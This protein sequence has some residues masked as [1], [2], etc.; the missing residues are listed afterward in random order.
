MGREVTHVDRQHPARM[1]RAVGGL[2]RTQAIGV[3][4]Q[5][6]DHLIDLAG[7]Q[8]IRQLLSQRPRFRCIFPEGG[9]RRFVQVVNRVVVVG[10]VGI[11]IPSPALRGRIPDLAATGGESGLPLR[12]RLDPW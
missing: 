10:T 7:P 5:R 9:S 6:D 1:L 12:S 8:S 4:L 3:G 11:L 2:A